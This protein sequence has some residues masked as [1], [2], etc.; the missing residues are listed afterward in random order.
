MKIFIYKIIVA[1]VLFYIF[2]ELTIGKRLDFYKDTAMSLKDPQIRMDI[3]DK[4]KIELKKAIEKENY[5]TT[6]ERYLISN[7]IKKIQKEL[8]SVEDK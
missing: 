4:F 1:L 7:F 8:S 6:E 2:F 5:L 3:K